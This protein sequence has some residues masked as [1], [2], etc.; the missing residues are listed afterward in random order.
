MDGQTKEETNVV[1]AA[2]RDESAV[3]I[4]IFG[5]AQART[6]SN[7]QV[8]CAAAVHQAGQIPGS[9]AEV[10]IHF[11]NEIVL[12]LQYPLESR[13]ISW[14]KPFFVRP[15]KDMHLS[16]LITELIR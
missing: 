4:P 13:K 1:I 6:N 3:G 14:P 2:T 11:D 8:G 5:P 7:C 15:V 10:T 12:P 9:M 16:I